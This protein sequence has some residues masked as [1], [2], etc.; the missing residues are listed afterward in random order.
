MPTAKYNFE[1]IKKEYI[2]GT[3]IEV[4]DFLTTFLRLDPKTASNG[5]WKGKTKGWR[6]DKEQFQKEIKRLLKPSN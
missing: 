2:S 3:Y 1:E 5:Y 6:T 4:Q